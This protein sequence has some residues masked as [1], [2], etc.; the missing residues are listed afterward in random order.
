MSQPPITSDQIDIG[1]GAGALVTLDSNAL[2][3]VQLNKE[4]T[5]LFSGGQ[6][7]KGTETGSPLAT[8]KVSVSAGSGIIVDNHTDPVNPTYQLITWSA[9]TDVEVTNIVSA[10]R[11]F[12]AIAPAGSPLGSPTLMQQTI[13]FTESEHRDYIV[14]GVVG[15]VTNVKVIAVRS[16]PHAAFDANIRLGD[17]A[18]AI[19]PFNID[20][21]VY[22]AN[23]ANLNLDK[24]FG[25][26][27]R[28]GNNFHTDKSSPDVTTDTV[29]TALQFNYSY[30][31]GG[32]GYTLTGKVTTVDPDFYDSGIGTLT[33]VPTND[34]QV[35]IIK[36][37]PGGGGHRIE[38]GQQTYATSAAAIDDIPDIDHLHNPAF[39]DGITRSYLVVQENSTNL[40][41]QAIFV[42]SSK[43]AGAGGGTGGG[44]VFT[45]SFESTELG[46]AATT[47]YSA[48]HA[49]GVKPTGMQAFLICKT[50]EYGYSID[51]EVVFANNYTAGSPAADGDYPGLY[52]NATTIY[53]Y[54]GTNL[55]ITNR[56]NGAPVNITFANWK[57]ILRAYA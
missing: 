34:W 14:L 15:H 33:A 46:I 8:T 57:I 54:S 22:N 26:S 40:S 39:V 49:L 55:R 41:T 35:Q 19:G 3:P 21:N 16:D 23:G 25:T 31:D 52:A 37:F 43:F 20:G 12:L 4:S 24:T 28:L 5:G 7:S 45:S 17:L 10:D 51:D 32:T 48:A 44:G 27:Y 42:E 6:I 36:H 56:T 9:F 2:L 11:T 53:W 29:D 13:Q 30:Q 47:E 18:H 1:T 38:Y 50:A